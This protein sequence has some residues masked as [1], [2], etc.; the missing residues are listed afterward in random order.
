MKSL[1]EPE[2]AWA[3]RE[4]GIPRDDLEERLERAGLVPCPG[5]YAKGCLALLPIG[6]GQILCSFCQGTIRLNSKKRQD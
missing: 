1:T 5:A 4:R 2:M 3:D 6:S